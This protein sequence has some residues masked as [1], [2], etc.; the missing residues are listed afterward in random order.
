MHINS[1]KG[2][3]TKAKEL[4]SQLKEASRYADKEMYVVKKQ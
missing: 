2:D 4:E 1:R 3:T